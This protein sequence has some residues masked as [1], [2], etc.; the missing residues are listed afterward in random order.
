[1]STNNN[2]VEKILSE[3]SF[4]MGKKLGE[5]MFSTVKLGTHSLTNEQVAIKI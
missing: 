3:I 1:M 4:K 5:G 2:S